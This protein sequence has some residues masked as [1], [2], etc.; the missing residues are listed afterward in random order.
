MTVLVGIRCSDGIVI[1]SDSSS[2]F[3]GAGFSTIEQPSKKIHTIENRMVLA[4]TGQVGLGQRFRYVI[5]KGW[6]DRQ[7]T[8]LSAVPFASK[9]C[10]LA[11]QDFSTTGVQKN[12]FG[13]LL[14]FHVDGEFNLCEYAVTDLQPE[15]KT[16]QLWYASM[17]S[18][19]LIADPFLAF[20]K[21]VFSPNTVPV[22]S[23]G[24][25]YAVWALAQTIE[26]NTGGIDGPI[27][28]AT[29]SLAGGSPVAQNL[30]PS[31]IQEHLD[32]VQDITRYLGEYSSQKNAAAESAIISA[33]TENQ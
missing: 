13:A 20:I 8:G 33:V 30:S 9:V 3:G 26:L 16:N 5:E 23:D 25:L 29:L 27:Q 2:T 10:Q 17:G 14:A 18:G 32:N 1:G 28:I 22:L 4:G 19:Q 7:F 24:I 21:K 15:L 31:D 12:E 6:K 11:L